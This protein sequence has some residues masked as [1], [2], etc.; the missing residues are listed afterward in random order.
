MYIYICLKMV[1]R[2]KYAAAKL[3]KIFKTIEIELC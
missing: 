2:P 3:N 1:V